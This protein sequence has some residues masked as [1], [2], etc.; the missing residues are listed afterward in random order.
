VFELTNFP[1]P[2]RIA[3]ADVDEVRK[4]GIGFVVRAKGDLRDPRE[5][6]F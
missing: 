1:L 6:E 5:T 2:G 3:R 4:I